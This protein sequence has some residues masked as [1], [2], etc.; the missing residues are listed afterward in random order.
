MNV[1]V[2]EVKEPSLDCSHDP[3]SLLDQTFEKRKETILTLM[4]Q[5]KLSYLCMYADLE[6]G[7]NFEYLSGFVP[8]FEEALLIMDTQGNVDYIFGNE[9]FNKAQYARVKGTVHLVSEF[10]LPDQP[11][12]GSSLIDALKE[13][14]ISGRVGIVGWKVLKNGRLDLPHFIANDLLALNLELVNVTKKYIACRSVNNANELAYFEYGASLAGDRMLVAMDQI[15]EGISELDLGAY[16]LADGQDPS[17]VTICAFKDRFKNGELYPRNVALSYGDPV[18]LTV[19]Y[20]GGLSSRSG[21]AIKEGKEDYVEKVVKPYFIAACTWLESLRVDM[22]GH[23]MYSI[24]DNVYQKNVYG[25]TLNPGHL[26]A[27]EEWLSSP[28][29]KDSKEVL[30]SGM[31]LQLDIIPSSPLGSVSVE[32]TV[33]LAN[34]TLIKD[35]KEQYPLLWKRICQRRKYIIDELGINLTECVL[36]MASTVGYLRPYLLNYGLA[37]VKEK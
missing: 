9:N 30:K 16:L 20:R 33:A 15:K 4:K 17:V 24:I 34:E 25:W 7:S 21:F 6:H 2:K 3:V 23:E 5:E 26:T 12:R 8:R 10:S 14:K 13:T 28:I 27:Q 18:S 31:I 19:G 32:C 11:D 29:Y 35:I 37:M 22:T 1:I 36:P